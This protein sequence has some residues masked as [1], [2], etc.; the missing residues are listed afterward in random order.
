MLAIWLSHY[1]ILIM[2][3]QIGVVLFQATFVLCVIFPTLRWIYVPAG[4]FMHTMIYFPLGAPFFAWIAL[5][6]VFIPWSAA[7][8][9]LGPRGAPGAAAA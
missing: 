9:R 4:L 3:A 1:H 5:Y 6:A 2:L 8:R 7:A